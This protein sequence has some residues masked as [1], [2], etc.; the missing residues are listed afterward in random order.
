VNGKP[1]SLAAWVTVAVSI[2]W[3]Y[4]LEPVIIRRS[5]RYL[6]CSSGL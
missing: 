1:I 2:S 3:A 4:R 6:I 5:S